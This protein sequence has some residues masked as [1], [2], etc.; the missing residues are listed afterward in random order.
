MIESFP[1]LKSGTPKNRS[2]MIGKVFVPAR[3]RYYSLRCVN[4]WLDLSVSEPKFG[5]NSFQVPWNIQFLN[6]PTSGL[7]AKHRV[8]CT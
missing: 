2:F 1:D 4:L 5:I 6:F 8:L 3:C 7:F